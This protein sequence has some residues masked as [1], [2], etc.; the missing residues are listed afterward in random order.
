MYEQQ[1]A[2]WNE[3]NSP[4]RVIEFSR[5]EC[6]FSNR[7]HTWQQFYTLRNAVLDILSSYGSVGPM[8]QMPILGSYEESQ[9]SWHGGDLNPDFL[10][11]MTT[12]TG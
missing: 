8:G 9:D 7:D 6:P 11:V 2:S 10:V 4:V 12:C 1:R 3:R 5:E